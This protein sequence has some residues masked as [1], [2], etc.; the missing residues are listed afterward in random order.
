MAGI[1]KRSKRDK[2]VSLIDFNQTPNSELFINEIKTLSSAACGI[3]VVRT[4]EFH[5]A[6]IS[7]FE[8]A[9]AKQNTKFRTW[10]VTDGWRDLPVTSRQALTTEQMLGQFQTDGITTEQEEQEY[11]IDLYPEGVQADGQLSLSGAM[12][13]YFGFV[14]TDQREGVSG[15]YVMFAPDFGFGEVGFQEYIR[16]ATSIALDRDARLFMIC[17]DSVEIPEVLHEELRVVDFLPPN[18]AELYSDLEQCLENF[19][20]DGAADDFQPELSTEDKQ[21]IVRNALGLS[22]QEFDTAVSVALVR[23]DDVLKDGDELSVDLIV[24]T[25]L[26]TK[27]EMI[28]KNPI[29]E[30]QSPVPI[31]HVGGLDLIKEWA[32]R[33][34]KS[35]SA[36]ARA[37]GVD[38]PKGILAAGIPGSGKSL[39]AKAL[40]SVFAVPCVSLDIGKVFGSLVG[41]S[42]GQMRTALKL[43]ESMAPC[44][45]LMDEIDKGFSN[46]SGGGDS[47]TSARVFG[48]FLTW[49]QDRKSD[50]KPVVVVFT[51]NNVE[52]LPPELLRK[53]RVD[54]IFCVTF[55]TKEERRAIFKI[56]LEKRGHEVEDEV[57]DAVIGHTNKYVGA[58]I[59]AIVKEAIL[60]A[61]EADAEEVE[62]KYLVEAAQ[63]MKPLATI[64]PERVEAMD[65]WAKSNAKP[66]SRGIDFEKITTDTKPKM[67]GR[68]GRALVR[69]PRSSSN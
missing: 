33:R 11:I 17:H 60:S 45:L 28:K 54:E 25:I 34:K 9:I 10:M 48:T 22:L 21:R 43:V 41:Q 38:M 67:H 51:A 3:V 13:A 68:G 50:D 2:E 35:F 47:G 20:V 66:A 64:F 61:F 5:R 39:I 4:R 23:Q 18:A 15:V 62:A 30:Y 6:A 1:K 36:E 24:D 14:E 59:E 65:A 56:H 37:F 63:G 42:E 32:T 8:F 16:R 49:M 52:G 69:K 29:L 19:E 7:L 12:D 55:P 40:S 31:E 58:E 44:V 26:E 27:L 46:T 57:I 53:G